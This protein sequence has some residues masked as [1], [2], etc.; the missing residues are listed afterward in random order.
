MGTQ[1]NG[2]AVK[3]ARSQ[4]STQSNEH[5]VKWPRSQMSTQSNG[6]AVKW[7]RSQMAFVSLIV[8]SN[9]VY[10]NTIRVTFVV[11]HS[12][13]MFIGWNKSVEKYYIHRCP[14]TT[15]ENKGREKPKCLDEHPYYLTVK[16]PSWKYVH[17]S[18]LSWGIDV[19][20]A[21]YCD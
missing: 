12:H 7:P 11:G 5:A 21:V 8:T 20:N 2:H 19:K 15:K 4:M 14:G 9:T 18:W 3:W 16:L 6:H 10:N 17:G 13:D 1:T